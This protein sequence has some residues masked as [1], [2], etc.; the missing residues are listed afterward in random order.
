MR[1]NKQDGGRRQSISVPN[2]EVSAQEETRLRKEGLR[3]GDPNWE[4][5][6][7][8]EYITKPR[9]AATVTGKTPDGRPIDGDYR[10]TDEFSMTEGF[11]ENVEFF[12]MTYESPRPVAHNRAFE[13]IAPLL[14]LRAGSQG[15]RLNCAALPT[16]PPSTENPFIASNRSRGP[17]MADCVSSTSPI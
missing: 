8:C 3:P 11:E 9:I 12:T 4:A 14:W 13:A 1:L 6:G 17:K 7:I 15:R 16:L 10:F 2:N 5:R